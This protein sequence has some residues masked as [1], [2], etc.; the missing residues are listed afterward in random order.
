VRSVLVVEDDRSI[1]DTLRAMLEESYAVTVYE[2]PSA[3]PEPA[4][5][6]LVI[7]DLLGGNG[8]D[9]RA[10]IDLVQELRARTGAPVLVLTAHSAA[11]TDDRLAEVATAVL[12]KPFQMDELLALVDRLIV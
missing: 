11:K 9:S 8:Y 7:T 4:G 1:A 5:A 3:V 12:A 10:A 2:A 6:H